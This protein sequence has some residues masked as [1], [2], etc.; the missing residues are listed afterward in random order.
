MCRHSLHKIFVDFQA[1]TFSSRDH[2]FLKFLTRDMASFKS[3]PQNEHG[4]YVSENSIGPDTGFSDGLFV[5]HQI[6]D[7]MSPTQLSDA[8]HPGVTWISIRNQNASDFVARFI[9]A[10]DWLF[11]GSCCKLVM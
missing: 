7:E 6:S 2:A 11:L 8:F 1:L 4:F 3:M 10:G 9:H 5:L